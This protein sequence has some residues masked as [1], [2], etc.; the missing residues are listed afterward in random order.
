MDLWLSISNF[1]KNYS[2]SSLPEISRYL[3]CVGQVNEIS[4]EQSLDLSCP[5]YIPDLQVSGFLESL[6]LI[7]VLASSVVLSVLDS[8]PMPPWDW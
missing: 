7:L 6:T 8:L 4:F 2:P 1:L 3:N 5:E